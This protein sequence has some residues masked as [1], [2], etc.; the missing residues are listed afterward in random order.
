MSADPLRT[1]QILSAWFSPGYPVGA[2]SYSH[3]LEWAVE[4]GLVA[5]RV[6]LA[7]WVADLLEFGAGRSDAM[8]LAAAWRAEDP[9]PGRRAR[10]GA[11]AFV[12]AASG[13]DG[14]GRGLRADHRRGLGDCGAGDGLPGRRRPCRAALELPLLP[15]ATLFLQ[16]F[17]ANIVS[18]GVRLIPL[19]QTDGQRVTAGLLPLAAAV[20]EAAVAAPPERSA[21]SRSG[22][23]SRRCSTRP[24]IA[25]SSAP[26]GRAPRRRR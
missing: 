12:R 20:A 18:A 16:S 26:D 8:L 2:F 21:A 25:G 23:I 22:P 4:A 5:G 13:D 7:A 11:G 15:T 9:G 6:G 3:G 10:R 19:G 17:A 1:T 14:A 24:S